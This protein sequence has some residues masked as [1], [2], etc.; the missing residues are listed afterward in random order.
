MLRKKVGGG[1]G[2]GGPAHARPPPLRLPS[3]AGPQL[4]QTRKGPDILLELGNV[5]NIDSEEKIKNFDNAIEF[6]LLKAL[7]Y[8]LWK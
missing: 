2:G 3:V 6:L 4:I 5:R 7:F 8:K 1:G